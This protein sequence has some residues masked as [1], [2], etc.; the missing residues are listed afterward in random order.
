MTYTLNFGILDDL[1]AH[2]TFK[3]LN[4]KRKILYIKIKK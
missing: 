2:Y 1:S 3:Q 4:I